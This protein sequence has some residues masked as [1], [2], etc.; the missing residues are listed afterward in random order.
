MASNAEIRKDVGVLGGSRG[1][2]LCILSGNTDLVLSGGKHVKTGFF[3][4]E[5]LRPLKRLLD[6]GYQVIFANPNGST[7]E[8]DP[9]SDSR[10]WFGIHQGEYSESKELLQKL[11][12]N[13]ESG[14]FKNPRLLSS[15]TEE[16][17]I[18]FQ[19][20]FLP[21]GHAPMTDLA[22]DNDCGRIVSYFH[23][24]G[25][26]IGAICH[27]P[28]GL[29]AAKDAEGHWPFA[30]Y[31]MTCYSDSEEKVNELMWWDK[32]TYHLETTLAGRGAQ[33]ETGFPMLPKVYVDR[34]LI[35]GQQPAS[36]VEFSEAFLT[37]LNSATTLQAH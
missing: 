22:Q 4:S 21:G 30:G 28:A 20:I 31:R 11:L 16:E 6:A 34:E 27:G 13:S 12:Q 23:N 24:T 33:M 8:M 32:M 9:M 29:L 17:L 15:I 2:I 37:R 3:L 35:T 19:G 18:T 7:P 25:K 14:G 10:V 1:K 36:V 5:T 26:L